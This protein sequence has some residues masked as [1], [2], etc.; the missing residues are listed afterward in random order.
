MA[1]EKRKKSGKIEGA[2]YS[3]KVCVD[4]SDAL[5]EVVFQAEVS[6]GS[7][8][9]RAFRKLETVIETLKRGESQDETD[10]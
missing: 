4:I 9:I 3:V 1:G 7:E 2:R 10:P 5:H 6:D 8:L